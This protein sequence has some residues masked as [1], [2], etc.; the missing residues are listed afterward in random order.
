MSFWSHRLMGSS[1]D[2]IRRSRR[3]GERR[4][5]EVWLHHLGRRRNGG[6]FVGEDGLSSGC[7]EEQLHFFLAGKRALSAPNTGEMEDG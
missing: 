5:F 1:T 4:R 3:G 6:C 7:L 2:S